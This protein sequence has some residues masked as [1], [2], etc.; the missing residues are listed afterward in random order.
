MELALWGAVEE[1]SGETE[2]REKD[3]LGHIGGH[4]IDK[5]GKCS[6]AWFALHL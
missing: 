6:L 5:T 2:E 3:G 1:V 4:I